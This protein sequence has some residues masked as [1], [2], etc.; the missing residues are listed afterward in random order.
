MEQTASAAYPNILVA[1]YLRKAG[2][3]SKD[4]VKAN[5]SLVREG[6]QRM[7]TFQ[8]SEGGFSWWSGG[9]NPQVWVTAYG[10]HL[11]RDTARVIDV[12]PKPIARARAWLR[13]QQSASGLWTDAGATHGAGL[14]GI[15]LTAFV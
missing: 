2:R 15:A 3:A 11:L 10:L 7:L 13:R 8:S 14:D 6:Y 12:D 5:E 4:Q 1:D 9:G